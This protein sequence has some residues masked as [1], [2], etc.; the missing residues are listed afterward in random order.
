MQNVMHAVEKMLTLNG[1]LAQANSTMPIR[2]RTNPSVVRRI[3]RAWQCLSKSIG[4]FPVWKGAVT[5]SRCGF[6]DQMGHSVEL[7]TLMSREP[8]FDLGWYT[9]CPP[10][11]SAGGIV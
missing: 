4:G 6:V 2:A 5:C 3:Q 8:T 9:P 10:S 11:F 7:L 1:C